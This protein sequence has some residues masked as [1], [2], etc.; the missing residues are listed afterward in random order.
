M[1]LFRRAL[2]FGESLGRKVSRARVSRRREFSAEYTR[3]VLRRCDR[4]TGREDEGGAT[5]RFPHPRGKFA[6]ISWIG[7]TRPNEISFQ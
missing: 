2:I 3:D 6:W 4:K 1:R 7:G 5:E